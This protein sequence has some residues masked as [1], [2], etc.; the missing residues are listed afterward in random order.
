MEHQQPPESQ[1]GVARTDVVR[2]SWP[3]AA[4]ALL[5]VLTLVLVGALLLDRQLRAPVGLQTAAPTVAGEQIQP[6][7]PPAPAAIATAA[8]TPVPAATES[9]TPAASAAA[10]PSPVPSIDPQLVHEIGTAYERYWTVRAAS[11]LSLDTSYL[12][13]VMAGDE[14][15]G[16]TRL[17]EQLR[18]EGRSVKTDVTLNYT[19]TYAVGDEAEVYDEYISRSRYVNPDTKEPLG[20][21]R[22]PSTFKVTHF[23]RKVGGTWKVIGEQR[24]D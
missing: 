20:V 2:V 7:T 24:H 13:E 1:A 16:A 10:S 23:M 19:V 21:E 9:A 14:L 12:A 3:V 17:I 11:E 8:S 15:A 22:A 4:A 6:T 5:G 18:S